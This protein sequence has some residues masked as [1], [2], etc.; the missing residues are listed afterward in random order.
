MS[1]VKLPRWLRVFLALTKNYKGTIGSLAILATL[2]LWYFDVVTQEK[3]IFGVILL[4]SGGFIN[5]ENIDFI[6][7]FK[8]LSKYKK[9]GQNEPE[10]E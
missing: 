4:M 1:D 3:A 8:H 7:F 10:S 5:S 2:Y 9:G 6:S